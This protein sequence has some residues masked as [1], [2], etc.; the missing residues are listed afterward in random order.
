[1]QMRVVFFGDSL[2]EG[3][4]GSSYLAILRRMVAETPGLR[5]VDLINAGVGGDTVEHLLS[6]LASDVASHDPDWVVV[7]IGGNDATTWRIN[8]GIWRRLVYWRARRYFARNRGITGAITPRRFE[9]GLRT[10]VAEIR[11]RTR[12]RV[13]LCAPQPHGVETHSLRWRILAQYADVIRHVASDLGCELIDL[14]ATWSA[15]A[16]ALPPRS[17]VARW[18]TALGV[19]RGD[20]GVDIDILARQRGYVLTFDGIHFSTQGAMLVAQVM[21][22]WLLTVSTRAGEAG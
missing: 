15:A 4:H 7:F 12:A 13:A 11:Q 16:C 5:D 19:L 9:A 22:D 17:L 21:Y 18:R 2:T 8:R 6:R 20:G 10:V 14:H 1:M 3:T